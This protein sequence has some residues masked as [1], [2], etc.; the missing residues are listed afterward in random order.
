MDLRTIEF[1]GTPEGSVMIA[2]QGK[3][4][5]EYTESERVFTLEMIEAIKDFYPEAFSALCEIYTKS[6]LN[7]KYYEYLIVHRFIRCNFSEYDNRP[8]VDSNGV[9]AFEFV[10]CP[11]RGECKW[12][13]IICN[14]KFNSKLSDRELEVMNCFY[15]SM[16]IDEIADKLFIAIDT[17]KKHK[18]NV[19][20]KMKMHSL[21]EFI[22]YAANNKLFE[23][24]P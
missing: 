16:K 10:S 4:L 17:V 2:D 19:L 24:E 11:L 23:N 18:R 1:Y 20:Q 6:Q 12:S 15:S 14:P 8:D 13:K 5:R 7:R 3:S 21:S 22:S 9:F